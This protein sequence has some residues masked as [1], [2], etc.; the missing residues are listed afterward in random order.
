MPLKFEPNPNFRLD[1]DAALK[2]L[3]EQGKEYFLEHGCQ[4]CQS[5]NLDF[6]INGHYK[7]NDCGFEAIFPKDEL[8]KHLDDFETELKNMFKG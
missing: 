8:F 6:S 1:K 2:A 5:K 7:C 4:K 3:E